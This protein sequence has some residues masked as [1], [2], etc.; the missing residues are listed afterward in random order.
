MPVKDDEIMGL[1]DTIGEH[2]RTNIGNRYIRSAFRTLPLSQHAWAMIESLTEKSEYY[3]LQ[4]YHFDELYDR[5]MAMA[6]FIY[7]S[8]KEIAPRLRNLLSY[9]GVPPVGN[10]RVLRDMAVNNFA[11]NLSILGDMVN[12]LYAMTV[13]A[14]NKAHARGTPIHKRTRGLDE[15]GRYLVPK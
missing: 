11:S 7:H 1:I 5:I 2:Y 10:E 13:E 14:D 12:K 15:I 6:E 4:G 8:R 3:T 9:G